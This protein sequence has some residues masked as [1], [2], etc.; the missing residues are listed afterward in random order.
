MHKKTIETLKMVINL[1]KKD[2]NWVKQYNLK[3]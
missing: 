3:Q 2:K 1:K